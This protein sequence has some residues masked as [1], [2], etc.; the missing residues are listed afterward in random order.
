MLDLPPLLGSAIP[1][2]GLVA[3]D[4]HKPGEAAALGALQQ[5]IDVCIAPLAAEHDHAGRYPT[6][7][8]AALK[9]CGILKTAVPTRFG[10]FGAGH[11]LS[12]EA[13]VRLAMADSSVAQVFKIHDELV[14]E[15]FSYCPDELG[16]VLASAVLDDDAILGLA[17]AEDG[18][19][20][21]A[22][23]ATTADRQDD[24]SY[25]INGS[26]VYTTGAAEADYIAVWAFDPVAGAEHPL[27]GLQCNLVARHTPGVTV[28]RDWD[29]LG[30]R[31][32]DSGRV[33]FREVRSEPR[34]R[35]STPQRPPGV[36]R[37]LRY[38]AGFA[39]VLVGLAI[40]A[41]NDSAQFLRHKARPWPSAGVTRAS[42]D[43]LVERGAGELVADVA[44]AYLL[45][46][47]GGALLDEFARGGLSRSAVAVPIS[48]AK[49]VATRA[50]LRATN[51][52]FTLMG[53]RSTRRSEHFDRYWRNARTLSLH[54][55]LEWKHL[56]IGNHFLNGWDP[57]PG[58]YT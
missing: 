54:D 49:S 53:T 40:A 44:A 12:L 51:E 42:E 23:M 17:A 30:Q 28:H 21:D 39:A 57:P 1:S 41:L 35:A 14:R 5:V 43:P 6:A 4:L 46:H 15:I 13:Q 3:P 52:V 37:S 8:V 36:D 32:T 33:T 45:V 25:V 50:S 48:V 26:K 47:Q 16:P 22:P 18:P 38:H 34:L 7:S 20:V 2:P 9:A 31:A 58:L 56:E 55:P 29:N 10:G 27:A 19:T 11:A 24:G